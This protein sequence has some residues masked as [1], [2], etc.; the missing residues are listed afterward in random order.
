MIIL[1]TSFIIAYYNEN[2]EKH[3]K[4]VELMKTLVLGKYGEFIISDY[5]FDEVVTVA[6]IRLKKMKRALEIGSDV[7]FFT[8]LFYLEKEGFEKAWDIF[9]GQ[10][11]TKLSFTDCSILALMEEKGIRY[12]ASFDEDFSKEERI[13]VVN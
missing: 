10:K 9:K 13:E 11:D 7:L 2:D 3:D 4:A 1:D 8:S 12:V 6:L 5:I